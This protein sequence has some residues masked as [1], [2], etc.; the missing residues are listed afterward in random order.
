AVALDVPSDQ[1]AGADA[2]ASATELARAWCE[3]AVIRIS[4][5]KSSAGGTVNATFNPSKCKLAA[6]TKAACQGRCTGAGPCDTS[7]NPMTCSGGAFDGNYC[8][9]DTLEG[10]CKVDARCDASCDVSV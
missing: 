6:A 1:Q 2:A 8:E 10:G 7:A 5:V 4:V 3:L 9:G